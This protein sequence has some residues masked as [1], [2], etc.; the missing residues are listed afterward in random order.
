MTLHRLQLTKV[1]AELVLYPGAAGDI[2]EAIRVIVHGPAFP[3]RALFPE[4]IVGGE[5]AERVSVATDGRS[6]HGYFKTVP[7]DRAVVSVRYGNSFAGTLRN[8]FRR[9]SV[10]PLEK[11]C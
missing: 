3:Q 6:I 11:N 10:R 9:D 5:I 4:L 8:A 2:V 1:E 7:A